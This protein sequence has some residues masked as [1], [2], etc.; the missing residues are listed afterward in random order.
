MDDATAFHTAARRYF[1]SE[2]LTSPGYGFAEE[3]LAEVEKLIP[4][5]PR[6]VHQRQCPRFHRED[7]NRNTCKGRR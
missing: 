2:L 4:A 3:A 6:R 1:E 5:Q 7:F